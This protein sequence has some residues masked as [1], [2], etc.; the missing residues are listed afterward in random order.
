[1]V[2][3]AA[4]ASRA[5][6]VLRRPAMRRRVVVVADQAVSALSNTLVAVLVARSA[7]A[8]GFGAFSLAMVA[9]QLVVGGVRALVGE[10]LLSL[11][12]AERPSVRRRLEA[13]LQG[14]TLFLGA[15]SAVVL[16]VISSVIGGISGAALLSLAA[17]LV[18]ILVQDAWR[19]VFIVD[20]P[21]AALG[22]DLVWLGVVMVAL[23][24]A[25]D[26]VTVTWYVIAWGLAG[27]LGGLVG[28]ALGW[29]LPSWPHPWQWLVA[30][31]QVGW[32][33]FG[34]FVTARASSQL[35]LTGVGAFAGLAALGAAKASFVY[36]G[37]LNTLHTGIY[38][39][40]VPEGTRRR[41]RPAELHRMLT[42]VSAGLVVVAVAWMVAGVLLPDAWGRQLFGATWDE[43]EDLM[44]P[45]GLAMVLGGVASGGLL[46]L[47]SLADA[48]RSLRARLW[49]TPWLV[50]CPLVGAAWGG[51][52]GFAAGFALGRLPVSVIWWR[53]FRASLDD[54]A[55][56]VEA[57]P[58]GEEV[59]RSVDTGEEEVAV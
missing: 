8:A 11:Y 41:D 14:S 43:A 32:R 39:A 37:I 28:L 3:V 6:E 26:H 48:Q 44:V 13:D 30:H 36:Y 25:P 33:Y 9:S 50:V 51:A 59:F 47:R 57:A 5:A 58:G 24:L 22:I 53:A 46:G 42:V 52:A 17:V 27:G 23:P 40:V 55:R 29:G 54:A 2:V 49:S 7:T 1:M 15:I 34:E 45:M 18:P 10:P 20:R 31:K 4:R 19:Y 16:V 21:A 56:G 35:V 12:S 38:L